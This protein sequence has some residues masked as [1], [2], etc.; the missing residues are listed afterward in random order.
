MFGVL[1]AHSVY[2]LNDSPQTPEALEVADGAEA[3]EVS[4]GE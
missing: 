3:P 2:S 1:H 4:I